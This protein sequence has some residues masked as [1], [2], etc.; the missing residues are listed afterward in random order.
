MNKQKRRTTLKY[1]IRLFT[2]LICG[3]SFSVT[4]QDAEPSADEVVVD[5]IIAKVDNYIVLKSE[6]EKTHLNALSQGAPATADLKCRILAQLISGKLMVAKAEID[7]VIVSD[8]EVDSNLERRMQAILSQYGGTEEQFEEFYGK[9]I[10]ELQ[11]E[12][13]DQ[14]KEQ[15]VVQRMQETITEGLSVTPSE[16]RKFFERIPKDSL[17][18]FS[19]EVMVSQIVKIPEANPAE[20]NKLKVKLAEIRSRALSGESF[21]E[22]AKT[23]SEGPSARNGGNLGWAGR[24]MMAP[25]FEAVAMKLKPNEISEP[26]ETDFGIHIVKLLDKRGNEYNSQHILLIPQSTE[27][28]FEMAAKE[29]DSLRTLVME[30]TLSFEKL[31]KEVSDD[32]YTA[33][34]G[35]FIMDQQGNT[36]VSVDQMDPVVYFTLTDSMSVGE[37]SKPMKFRM[38]DGKDAMRILYYK[39]KIQPHQAN[40]KDDWQKIQGAALEE[41]KSRIIEEWFNKARGDVFI[42]IDDEYENCGIIN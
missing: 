6:L 1:T 41:K 17:P 42:S 23:Y 12:I 2:L 11:A 29:L 20:L 14:I 31:A 35:G 37:I 15:M 7:S 27:E 34:G 36:R 24:G 18:F 21:E 28:D 3:L 5:E 26:F 4:A 16:V 10:E 22:L 25:A 19:T 39:E 9:T 38:D 8:L 13:R 40:L 33:G 32:K 30:D